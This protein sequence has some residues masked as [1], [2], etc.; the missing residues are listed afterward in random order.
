SDPLGKRPTIPAPNP[1]MPPRGIGPPYTEHKP[2]GPS[3]TGV[4]EGMLAALGQVF[5]PA[6]VADLVLSLALGEGRA[7]ARVLDPSCGDG[8]FLA[9]ANARGLV[10][11]GVEL[12]PRLAAA[13]RERAAGPVQ[14]EVADF[15]ALPPPKEPFDAVIGN[16][17]Y[18]RQEIV[19]GA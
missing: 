10:A 3:N 5:T 12:E 6:P 17:P 8:V 14:V 4:K 7:G 15:L 16:P 18:V 13:A 11:H 19:G 9:R 1:S 2:C